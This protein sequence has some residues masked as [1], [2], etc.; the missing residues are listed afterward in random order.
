MFKKFLL[1]LLLCCFSAGAIMVTAV[2]VGG[3]LKPAPKTF[4]IWILDL[5]GEA[6]SLNVTAEDYT[7]N[8]GCVTL[9]PQHTT[10][11]RVLA[12]VAEAPKAGN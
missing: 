3:F 2:L 4:T 5:A 7:M 8:S 10:F 9:F 12:V 11:C 1:P 6:Q